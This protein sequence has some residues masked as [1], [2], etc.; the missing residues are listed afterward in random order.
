MIMDLK[1]KR[2]LYKRMYREQN[3]G[4]IKEKEAAY[5]KEW[6][7][8]NKDKM[9]VAQKKQTKNLTDKYIRALLGISK[10]DVTPEIQSLIET[11]KINLKIKRLCKTLQ[12]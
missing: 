4:N 12:N 3:K 2:R 1:E 10:S 8:K 7:K 6:A 9:D 11:Y 5:K